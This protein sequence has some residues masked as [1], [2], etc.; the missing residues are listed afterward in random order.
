MSS[1]QGLLPKSHRDFTDPQY[2]K[3]FFEKYEKP[4]EWFVIFVPSFY[5]VNC[6][7]LRYGSYDQLHHVMEKYIKV[8]DSILELGC[9]NSELA[10]KVRFNI[11]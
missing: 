4:F 9:G 1:L 11:V 8:S 5:F 6:F 3:K 2:W 7:G 10:E